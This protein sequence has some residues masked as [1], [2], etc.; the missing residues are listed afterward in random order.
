MHSCAFFVVAL[1]PFTHPMQCRVTKI[2]QR[3]HRAFF[4]PIYGDTRPVLKTANVYFIIY[5]ILKAIDKCCSNT[6]L[7]SSFGY[8]LITGNTRFS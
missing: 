3:V 2:C 6:A 8:I 5:N 4:H 1:V 7:V